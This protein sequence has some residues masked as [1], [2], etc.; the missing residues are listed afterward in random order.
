MNHAL[1]ME[2]AAR[3]PLQLT[4]GTDHKAWAKWF[5]YRHERGDKTLSMIQ[6]A[7]SHQAMGVAMPP[8]SQ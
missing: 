6:V 7:F 5:M 8:P 4:T 3:F 2:A 1:E